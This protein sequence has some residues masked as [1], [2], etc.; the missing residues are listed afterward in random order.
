MPNLRIRF[1]ELAFAGGVAAIAF[2]EYAFAQG[3]E[4]RKKG[5]R[6]SRLDSMLPLFVEYYVCTVELAGLMGSNERQAARISC[7]Q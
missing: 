4:A 1:E 2:G 7:R 3:L 6:R 5:V